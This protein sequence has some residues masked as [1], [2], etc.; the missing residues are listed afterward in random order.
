MENANATMDANAVTARLNEFQRSIREHHPTWQI[1][2]DKVVVRCKGRDCVDALKR[3]S[4][5]GTLFELVKDT[6]PMYHFQFLISTGLENSSYVVLQLPYDYDVRETSNKMWDQLHNAEFFIY[7]I[8]PVVTIDGKAKLQE[9][10]FAPDFLAAYFLKPQ[11]VHGE[12]RNGVDHKQ[13]GGCPVVFADALLESF[14]VHCPAY[15]PK[16]AVELMHE[17]KN[18]AQNESICLIRLEFDTLN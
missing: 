12:G 1:V 16:N 11:D 18:N 5:H 4:A 6:F 8:F 15:G 7:D 9:Y 14:I 2:T 13:F 3:A 10:Y 17:L